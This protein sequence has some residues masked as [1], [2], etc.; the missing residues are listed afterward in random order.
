M[1]GLLSSLRHCS[2]FNFLNDQHRA[3][4]SNNLIFL[5]GHWPLATLPTGFVLVLFYCLNNL[6]RKYYINTN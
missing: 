1:N 6:S 2:L 4:I 5:I 3:I